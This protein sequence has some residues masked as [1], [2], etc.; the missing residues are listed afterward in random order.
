MHFS[1]VTPPNQPSE[2]EDEENIYFE[3]NPKSIESSN[4]I[5]KVTKN[6]NT[7]KPATPLRNATKKVDKIKKEEE[8]YDDIGKQKVDNDVY[9]DIDQVKKPQ[10]PESDQK[11][12]FSAVP[13][14]PSFLYSHEKRN[15]KKADVRKKEE[16]KQPA[17][18]TYDELSSNQQNENIYDDINTEEFRQ[19]T[20]K[21]ENSTNSESIREANANQK[22]S[23]NDLLSKFGEN[24]TGAGQNVPRVTKPNPNIPTNSRKNSANISTHTSNSIKLN[25]VSVEMFSQVQR[26]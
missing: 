15:E 13:K 3:I 21:L 24:S 6:K 4:M 26:K 8:T 22:K 20:Q 19:N 17:E 1:D 16:K 11:N 10:R 5:P 9:D 25:K 18:D 14:R 2:T 23:F 7:P 12:F